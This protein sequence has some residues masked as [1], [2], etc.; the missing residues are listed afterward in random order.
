[1]GVQ[2]VMNTTNGKL[3]GKVA[4]VTGGGS[5][6]GRAISI[7]FASEGAQVATAT[8]TLA[9]AEETARLA[10][11]DTLAL[12]ADVSDETAVQR[13]VDQTLSR[14][15]RIDILC[16]NAGIGTTK[17]IVEVEPE[18]WDRVFAVN[19]RGVYLC[20]RATLPQMLERRNGIVINIAS[21]LGLVG[22][23]K[24]AAYCAS[25]GAVITLTKQVATDFAGQG[26]RCNCIC[27]GTVDSPWVG[28]LLDATEDPAAARRALEQRHPLGRLATTDEVAHAALYLAS[29][30]AAFMTGS[31]LVMDGGQIAR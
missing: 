19:V 16:N 23:P 11:G 12:Q 8:R 29:D 22:V 26:I 6:I 13:M 18:E 15:G 9:H 21:V 4:L 31:A 1:M 20:T 30:D 17:S 14:F 2:R 3:S 10:G 25:K 5:G 27:P 7:L 24:R 28:R